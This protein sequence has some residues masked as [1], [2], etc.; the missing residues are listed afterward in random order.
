MRA[1][2]RAG[3]NFLDHP[4]DLGLEAYG[5]SLA[6]TFEQAALGMISIIVDPSTVEAGDCREV[7]LQGSGYEHL[8]V[9]WLQEILYLYDGEHF[10]SRRFRINHLDP[11]RLLA[12]VHG[13]AFDSTRHSTRMDIKAVTYHQLEVHEEQEI[14]R[15]RVFLDI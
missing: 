7:T 8:L 2:N 5:Q 6:E 14:H 4:A 13:E 15:V 12:V 1:V 3:F 11:E 10:V 9:R